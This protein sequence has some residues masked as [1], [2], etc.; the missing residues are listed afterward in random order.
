MSS[1]RATVSASNTRWPF[2]CWPG[3]WVGRFQLPLTIP[4]WTIL[5]I[6]TILLNKHII[7]GY[8]LLRR[9]KKRTTGVPVP[10]PPPLLATELKAWQAGS[11]HLNTEKMSW[12]QSCQLSSMGKKTHLTDFIKQIIISNFNQNNWH[13][14]M[15]DSQ[16]NWKTW[17]RTF[18]VHKPDPDHWNQKS[19]ESLRPITCLIWYV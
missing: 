8:L 14:I 19:M 3:H 2:F 10:P 18:D 15:K 11:Q 1:Q 5:C 4:E 16:G 13:P 6:V 12:F 9:K 17:T 7:N